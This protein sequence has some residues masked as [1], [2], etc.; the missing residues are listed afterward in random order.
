MSYNFQKNNFVFNDDNYIFFLW[1]A[2]VIMTFN[3]KKN[4]RG[5]SFC[6]FFCWMSD[7]K[8]ESFDF[9]CCC[10]FCFGQAGKTKTTNFS[11]DVNIIDWWMNGWDENYHQ[12]II[13]II[14]IYK[15]LLTKKSIIRMMFCWIVEW[16]IHDWKS[17]KFFKNYCCCW[18]F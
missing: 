2:M 16:N 7:V 4:K 18:N 1:L 14:I 3:S 17:K 11:F 6:F 13:I 12:L 8:I 5:V 15:L 10:C 9:D